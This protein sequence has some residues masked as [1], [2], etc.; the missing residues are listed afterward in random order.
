MAPAARNEQPSKRPCST[1]VVALAWTPRDRVPPG[2]I[3]S[4]AGPLTMG[5]HER[6]IDPMADAVSSATQPCI[7]CGRSTAAGSPRFAGRRVI[8]PDAEDTAAES[9]YL[10]EECSE[11][12]HAA[13]R[14]ARLSDDQ[15]RAKIES[16]EI[17]G[18]S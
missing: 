17:A 3:S 11:Q 4:D 15:L 13:E 16:G 6:S 5:A 2:A 8:P 9:S 18:W 10:C 12:I 7:S 14:E 1:K